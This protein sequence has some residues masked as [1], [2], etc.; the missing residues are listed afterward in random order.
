MKG[1]IVA[2]E[3]TD[4]DQKNKTSSF[5]QKLI[6]GLGI[7]ALMFVPVFKTLT[8]LPPFMGILFGLGVLWVVTE[9]IHKNK[10]DEDKDVYSVVHAL[11]KSDVP[12]VLFFLGILVAISALDVYTVSWLAGRLYGSNNWQFKYHRDLDR[13]TFI[14]YR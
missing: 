2:P 11:R 8:H 1:T 6:L 10:N 3:N 4:I 14:C 7:G 13:T 12:S 5:E 9:I